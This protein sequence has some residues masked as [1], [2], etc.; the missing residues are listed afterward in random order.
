MAMNWLIIS[1]MNTRPASPAKVL[2][3]AAMT[4]LELGERACAEA[5]ADAG[6]QETSVMM[7]SRLSMKGVWPMRSP[8]AGSRSG[9]PD[10]KGQQQHTD[11][12]RD[13]RHE[14]ELESAC[15]VGRVDSGG[16]RLARQVGRAGPR[17]EPRLDDAL[18]DDAP[19]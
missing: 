9:A 19:P 16:R 6:E 15:L 14:R 5:V 1:S 3:T 7:N 18:R 12:R 10:G 8:V 13:D 4:S 2:V 17:A 11:E